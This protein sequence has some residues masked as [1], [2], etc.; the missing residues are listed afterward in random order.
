MNPAFA[1]LFAQAPGLANSFN[2]IFNGT[3]TV[4]AAAPMPAALPAP[5]AIPS[6]DAGK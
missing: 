6:N 4:P 2:D 3:T 5:Q 1:S